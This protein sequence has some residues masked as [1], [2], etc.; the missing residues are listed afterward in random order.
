MLACQKPLKASTNRWKIYAKSMLR[1]EVPKALRKER[2]GY[3]KGNRS[4]QK[5]QKEDAVT[6]HDVIQI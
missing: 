4:H 5:A 2:K 6:H 3:A 1:K